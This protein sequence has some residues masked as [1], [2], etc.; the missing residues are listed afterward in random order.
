MYD[1]STYENYI[2]NLLTFVIWKCV[3]DRIVY[4]VKKRYLYFS[5]KGVLKGGTLLPR[6]AQIL[7]PRVQL[8]DRCFNTIY[9]EPILRKDNGNILAFY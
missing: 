9:N 6:G 7:R 1:E 5:K 2:N 8:H 3:Y 4:I